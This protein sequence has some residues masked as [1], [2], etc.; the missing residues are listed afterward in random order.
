MSNEYYIDK[1]A[2]DIEDE[3]YVKDYQENFKDDVRK[4]LGGNNESKDT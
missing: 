2:C 3:E 4:I 1:F